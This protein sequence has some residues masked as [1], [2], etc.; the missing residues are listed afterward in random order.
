MVVSALNKFCDFISTC[1]YHLF[2]S[3]DKLLHSK[4]KFIS[5]TYFDGKKMHNNSLIN[6]FT[7]NFQVFFFLNFFNISQF[8]FSV[9][10][11][12]AREQLGFG[13]ILNKLK[14]LF[15]PLLT[16]WAIS[17]RNIPVQ[18]L[19]GLVNLPLWHSLASYMLPQALLG[20]SSEYRARKSSEHYT[21]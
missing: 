6:L 1:L 14:F 15:G 21:V 3:P 18:C 9:L 5:K 8:P 11:S 19:R 12:I 10:E 20:I 7:P 13:D 4:V 16:L 17:F 2:L